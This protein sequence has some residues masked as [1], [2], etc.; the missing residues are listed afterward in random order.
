VPG[1]RISTDPADVDFE[2]LHA[3]LSERSTWARGV[4]RDVVERAL[5]FSLCFS[6]RLDGRFA[7]F[8]RVVTDR[9]TFAYLCDVFVLPDLRGRGLSKALMAAVDAHPDLQGL[10]RFVLA[11]SDAHGLYAQI[12]FTALNQPEWFMERYRPDVYSE[13][14][15]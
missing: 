9:A 8:A 13:S 2:A 6:L 3:F 1:V 4:P 7:G 14:L 5:A 11:T 15:P 12:G 10:R